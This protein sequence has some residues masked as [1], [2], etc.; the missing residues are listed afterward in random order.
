MPT[1]VCED[2]EVDCGNEFQCGTG[3]LYFVLVA[4]AFWGAGGEGACFHMLVFASTRGLTSLLEFSIKN[5][6]GIVWYLT[7][8]IYVQLVI[9]AGG[10]V[11]H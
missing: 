5:S 7:C 4:F 6:K 10:N 1:E 2:A 8:G 9:S 3:N 11:C